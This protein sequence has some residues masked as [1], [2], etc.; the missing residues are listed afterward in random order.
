MR[1]GGLQ[2]YEDSIHVHLSER[3]TIG[4]TSRYKIVGLAKN[5]LELPH[6]RLPTRHRRLSQEGAHPTTF[7]DCKPLNIMILQVGS[8]VFEYGC[9][10]TPIL[11]S[12]L[13]N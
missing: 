4:A 13:V 2:A 1:Y 9:N 5:R 3:G 10:D 12:L 7:K 6:R 11:R 8:W